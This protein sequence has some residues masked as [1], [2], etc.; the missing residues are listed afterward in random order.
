I[1]VTQADFG[2]VNLYDAQ[3]GNLV[4]HKEQGWLDKPHSSGNK[5][6]S[7][8]A[9]ATQGIMRRALHAGEA[10]LVPDVL[11]DED[12]INLGDDTRSKVVVPIY[13]GGEPAGV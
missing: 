3:T 7:R 2:N 10:I 11:Q 5:P 6:Y 4:A 8:T 12:Y 1:Q 9:S 13:Y